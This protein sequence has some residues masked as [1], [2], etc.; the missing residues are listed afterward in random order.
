MS[1]DTLSWLIAAIRL[2]AG[3]SRHR[4]AVWRELRRLGAISI[5][6]GA[7]AA[8]AAAVFVAGFDRVAELVYR[9]DGRM[10]MLDAV[11]RDEPSRASLTNE[12]NA[13]R[14]E[15]WT[16][17]IS[18]CDKFEGEIAKEKR[19]GK[20]TVSELDE[21][22]Q[23]LD[24]LRRWFHELKARDVFGVTDGVQAEGHLRRCVQLLDSYADEVYQAVHAP[25]NQEDPD[26]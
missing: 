2:P 22:E 10:L 7:W 19:I 14:T 15:E 24:R 23:S 20:L 8:P 16:E 11:A 4:V 3:P 13:V 21:E 1:K 26:A 25:L 17:F 6:G 9:A 5:A 12:F 18:E